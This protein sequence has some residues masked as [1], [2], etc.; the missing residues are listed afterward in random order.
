MNERKNYLD[1]IRWIT[2]AVV[3]LYH[4]FY[5]FNSSGV[6]SNLGVTGI[7]Q[8]DSVCV[9]VYPWIM[10]LLFV[11]SG[12]SAKY[13]LK[14][15]SNKEFLKDRTKR[16]LIPSIAGI[17]AYGW[18]TGLITNYYGNIFGRSANTVPGVVK[19]IILSFVGTGIL[20]YAQTLFI[21]SLL[22]VLI[23][24]IDKNEKLDK[25]FS[26]INL[27]V[28]FLLCIL[29]W[30]S[31]HI[32]NMPVVTVFRFGIYTLMFLF[33][34][35]IFSN[36]NIIGKL[37]KIAMPLGIITLI[38][39]LVFTFVMY[40]SNFG[41]DEFLTNIFTNV[42]LWFVILSAFAIGKR[43]LNFSNKFTDY[44]NKNNFAF[45]VLH[46][47]VEITIAFA[48]A[49]YV[50]LDNFI[51]NYLLVL[52]G[53]I[54]VLPLLTEGIKRIPVINTL[55]LGSEPKNNYLGGKL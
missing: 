21:F 14:L 24:R 3:I 39:G 35:Y 28:L 31:S 48:L 26:K 30:G 53:T 47:T 6:I 37:E 40:G 50:R 46:Y 17:F 25:L 22:L 23:R 16:I 13:A 9:F 10:C 51:L 7:K 12:V 45:Y 42:Y 8:L 36:E 44:M 32:L 43:F 27:P 4:I 41:S 52:V 29:V 18:I 54:A 33:G 11:V 1:N 20:W 15:K 19:Y 49:E 34:Y 38:M 55:I 2:L 5:L